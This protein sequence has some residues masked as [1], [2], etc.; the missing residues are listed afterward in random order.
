MEATLVEWFKEHPVEYKR[1]RVNQ[2]A[3]E[4]YFIRPQEA[5]CWFI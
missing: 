2:V 3:I 1:M 4:Y 5:H